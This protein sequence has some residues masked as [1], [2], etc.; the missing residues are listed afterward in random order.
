ML[1]AAFYL[2][3]PVFVYF[4]IG[5]GRGRIRSFD[6][7]S[8]YWLGSNFLFFATPQ[9]LWLVAMLLIRPRA[10]IWHAGFLAASVALLSLHVI[11]ECCANNSNAL[12]WLFYYPLAGV[13]MFAALVCVRAVGRHNRRPAQPGA[14]PDLRDKAAQSG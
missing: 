12:G 11:F 10:P 1:A 9:M 5:I 6:L 13:L 2:A 7:D 3:L 14:Q 8:L 4:T